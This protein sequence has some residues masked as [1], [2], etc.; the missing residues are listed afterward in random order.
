MIRAHGVVDEGRVD[1]IPQVSGGFNSSIDS[2]ERVSD[3]L[4]GRVGDRLFG[5]A[6]LVERCPRENRL[7]VATS[8]LGFV[9]AGMT[10]TAACS[11]HKRSRLL[12]KRVGLAIALRSR[13]RGICPRS[14]EH[15]S[16][17]QSLRHLVCRLL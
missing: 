7:C 14:E 11:S 2:T 13:D 8:L 15:T 9:F 1:S 5:P 16:E 4:I 3:V 12:T 10:G 17:L 6:F